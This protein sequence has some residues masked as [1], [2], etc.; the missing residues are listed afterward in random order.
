MPTQWKLMFRS[1]DILIRICRAYITTVTRRHI[2]NK[3]HFDIL[4][5]ITIGKTFKDYGETPKV[6]T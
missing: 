2:D 1:K 6:P 4:R 3:R 5:A